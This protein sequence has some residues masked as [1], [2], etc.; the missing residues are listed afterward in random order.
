MVNWETVEY[1]A[2]VAEACID[3]FRPERGKKWVLTISWPDD[4]WHQSLHENSE[5]GKARAVQEIGHDIDWLETSWACDG[6]QDVRVSV[7]RLAA[8]PRD[9]FYCSGYARLDEETSIYVSC[10]VKTYEDAVRLAKDGIKAHIE[11]AEN[12]HQQVA[13]SLVRWEPSGYCARIAK[14]YASLYRTERPGGGWQLIVYPPSPGQLYCSVFQTM[15]EAEDALRKYTG[16]LW[17]INWR[18]IDWTCSEYKDAVTR[19]RRADTLGK[20]GFQGASHVQIDDKVYVG[21]LCHTRS[22]EQAARLAKTGV[23]AL[24]RIV[25]SGRRSGGMTELHRQLPDSEMNR[26]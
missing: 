9:G 13:G 20:K 5:E 15:K 18:E 21:N 26:Q 24:T 19:V 17:E 14:I 1:E 11:I 7:G 6:Y 10:R 3:L 8:P 25:L 4:K 22:Y 2:K 16:R 12:K 23:E